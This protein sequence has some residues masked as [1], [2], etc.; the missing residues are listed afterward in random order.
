M[1]SLIIFYIL[2]QAIYLGTA[3]EKVKYDKD[4][5][6]FSVLL[7]KISD[8]E[9]RDREFDTKLEE[10]NVLKERLDEAQ[11]RLR[12]M[13]ELE[14][15]LQKAEERIMMLLHGVDDNTIETNATKSDTKVLHLNE[16]HGNMGKGSSGHVWIR[17]AVSSI[18]SRQAAMGDKIEELLS[19]KNRI[20]AVQ[21]MA[22]TT[23]MKRAVTRKVAFTAMFSSSPVT[24]TKGQTLIFN[25]VDYNEGNAYDPYAGIFTCPVSGTYLFFT[26]ILSV[27]H[28]GTVETEIVVDG[29]GRGRTNAFDSVDVD[30]GTA[31]AA[32]H[33]TAGRRIWV[34][35]MAGTQTWGDM[36]SSFTGVLL[37][38]D[39]SAINSN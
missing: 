7:K 22:D 35:C 15:R 26:N 25:K 27:P 20:Q 34:K 29:I 16:T 38:P 1:Q 21:N 4:G 6:M 37:W 2:F 13:E 24:I 5:G 3:D 17:R 28:R 31:A 23:S 9:E 12:N 30:Q 32:L 36:Y 33:C 14:D 8:L 11:R 39:D 19:F 18:E 10:I